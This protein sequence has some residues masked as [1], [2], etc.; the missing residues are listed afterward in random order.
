MREGAPTI[1]VSTGFTDYGDYL[2]VALSRPLLA[3]G[4]VPLLLPYLEEPA[5][6]AAALDRADGLVLGFGRDIDPAR[7]GAGPH[8]ALT[9][10]SSQRDAFELALVHEALERDMPLLGICRGMQIVNVALGGTLYRD[11]SEYP[12][13]AR[14]HP[15]GDWARWDQVCAATLGS[16]P[17]P[18]HPS[19]PITVAR[20][21][22]LFAALGERAVVN[23]Y[24]HQAVAE[25]GR[26]VEA[27]ACA[28]D[29]IVEAIELPSY[30]FVVGVQWEL[31]ES[32]KDAAA[33]FAVFEAFVAAASG[34]QRSARSPAPAR[35]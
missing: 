15:G 3:A 19:H 10:V 17:M 35:S 13:G 4:A 24:H 2:G 25:L 21:S 11:R 18:S 34:R 22:R 30:R 33:C 9:A 28:D 8:P 1:A 20:G 26:D 5:A 29:G 31:Q 16:G 27:V 23:S 32:W 14:S 6:R 12:L 7:Y